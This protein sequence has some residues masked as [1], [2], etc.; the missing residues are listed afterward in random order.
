MWTGEKKKKAVT[1]AAECEFLSYRAACLIHPNKTN[2]ERNPEEITAR[3]AL[4]EIPQPPTLHQGARWPARVCAGI[5]NICKSC[6]CF[7]TDRCSTALSIISPSQ[8]M[9][10]CTYN[11]LDLFFFSIR[12]LGKRK[13]NKSDKEW[14]KTVSCKS[15][16]FLNYSFKKKK[17]YK[18]F[19]IYVDLEIT[20]LQWWKKYSDQFHYHT[21][22][23]SLH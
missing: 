1:T 13:K 20:V 17:K 16:P 2:R 15:E 7:H 4:Q 14:R 9:F 8:F 3:T 23:V 18:V 22:K 12:V 21:F 6:I 19:N 5:L 11:R 10:S